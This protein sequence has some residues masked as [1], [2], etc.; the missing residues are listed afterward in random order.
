MVGYLFS[1][2]PLR[3]TF[4]TLIVYPSIDFYGTK[5]E[6]VLFLLQ[7]N[8]EPHWKYPFVEVKLKMFSSWLSP[9]F[10]TFID[11]D[12]AKQL[13]CSTSTDS[14]KWASENTSQ[15]ISENK[16]D[17]KSL[18]FWY[19]FEIWFTKIGKKVTVQT[20]LRLALLILEDFFTV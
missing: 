16:R 17:T 10:W 19:F 4:W 12:A 8:F 11:M 1:S 6:D 5:F 13:L 18:K 3:V 7:N 14:S 20:C 15:P 9:F 2:F